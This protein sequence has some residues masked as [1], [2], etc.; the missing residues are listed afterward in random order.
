MH[1][2]IIHLNKIDS[3]DKQ[4]HRTFNTITNPHIRT[5]IPSGPVSAAS[6]HFS[7]TASNQSPSLTSLTTLQKQQLS[8][9]SHLTT[10]AFIIKTHTRL[11]HPAI[12][13][14]IYVLCLFM[15]SNIHSLLFFISLKDMKMQ[16]SFVFNNKI[17]NKTMI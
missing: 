7:S 1:K 4:T 13:S 11:L 2:R 5:L 3:K 15:H 17:L 16:A 9:L 6:L 8:L 14:A 12:S 10:L